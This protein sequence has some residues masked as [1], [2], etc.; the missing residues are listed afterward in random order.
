MTTVDLTVQQTVALYGSTIQGYYYKNDNTW[1]MVNFS[2][3]ANSLDF[4]P[5]A[6]WKTV[7][8]NTDFVQSNYPAGYA[9][10]QAYQDDCLG[11][12]A[13]VYYIAYIDDMP[14]ITSSHSIRFMLTPSINIQGIAYF[15]QNVGMSRQSQWDSNTAP[16]IA[17]MS[18]STNFSYSPTP[19]TYYAFGSGNYATSSWTTQY[20]T[21]YLGAVMTTKLFCVDIYGQHTDQ[22]GNDEIFSVSG[23]TYQFGYANTVTNP[24]YTQT[25][26][27]YGRFILLSISCPRVS[28]G[29][30]IPGADGSTPDY[31]GQLDDIASGISDNSTL[32]LHLLVNQI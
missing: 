13:H 24:E 8:V 18:V 9:S 14:N 10:A 26:P 7:V 12:M 4:N 11:G 16:L 3:Y 1:G 28:D 15:R 25:D 29:Y 22:N 17:D 30:I 27:T 32:L 19:V 2:Y 31:S 23:Q 6:P 5:Q 21:D 20:G